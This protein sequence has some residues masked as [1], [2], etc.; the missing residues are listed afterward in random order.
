MIW[1]DIVKVLL[2]HAKQIQKQLKKEKS[3]S[4]DSPGI[5]TAD[6]YAVVITEQLLEAVPEL[7]EI[8]Q[9]KNKRR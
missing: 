6:E 9:K 8:F 2:K 7:V 1:L 3:S 4:D 5:I